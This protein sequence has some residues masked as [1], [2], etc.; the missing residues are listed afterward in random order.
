VQVSKEQFDSFYQSHKEKLNELPE[1]NLK[2][3]SIT[4]LYE[5]NCKEA[6]KILENGGNIRFYMFD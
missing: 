2:E 4:W 1:W 5:D 6:C 3:Q